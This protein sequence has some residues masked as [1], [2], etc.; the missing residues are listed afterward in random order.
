[1]IAIERALRLVQAGFSIIPIREDKRP[2]MKWKDYQTRKATS[3]ELQELTHRYQPGGFGIVTG[4][5]GL[6]CV[7]VDL[8]NFPTLQE[9][10]TFFKEF[11]EMLHDNIDDFERKFVIYK[12]M[13][14]GYHILYKCLSPSG[15]VALAKRDGKVIVET[16]GEGGFVVAYKNNVTSL[17]YEDI[18]TISDE[19]REILLAVCRDFDTPEALVCEG[20][21][22]MKVTNTASFQ[23]GTTPWDD[24]NARKNVLDVVGDQFRI[25]R[26]L[27]DRILILR[28]GSKAHH[29]G[30]I[31]KESGILQ[32]W[33][34]STAYP[35]KVGHTPFSL[36]TWRYHGGNYSD[37]AKD[38]YKQGFGTRIKREPTPEIAAEEVVNKSSE[39][40]IDVF[41]KVL[42]N[43]LNECNKTL[44]VSI[45]YMGGALLWLSAVTIGNMVKLKVK[46]GWFESANIWLSLVGQAGIGK[47]PSTNV[48]LKPLLKTN[49]FE[50]KNYNKEYRKFLE[51]SKMTKDEKK[52]N[53]EV[54]EPKRNYFIVNDVT[55][56]ALVDLHEDVPTGVGVHK[57]ELAGW[58]KDMN[59]YREGSDKEFWLSCWSGQSVAITRKT[60][61]SNYV[62]SPCIPV[63]GGIQPSIFTSFATEENKDNGFIDRML[64]CY[65]DLVVQRINDNELSQ[66]MLDWYDGYINDFYHSCRRLFLKF[67]GMEEVESTICFFSKEAYKVFKSADAKLT[68]MQNSPK[69]NEYVK[70]M[71]AKQKSYLA[72]FSLL[73]HFLHSHAEGFENNTK[74][75]DEKCVIGAVKLSDYFIEMSK[76][77]KSDSMSSYELRKLIKNMN[78]APAKDK[79]IEIFSKMPDANKKE[80]AELLNITR[81]SI[82]NYLKNEPA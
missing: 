33:T 46:N 2:C 66:E 1:M 5:D 32:L 9:G 11:T 55:V 67:N 13:N 63:I 78:G 31:F 19:D 17:A 54:K 37:A 62:N 82:Y 25:V 10:Q 48:I 6:E 24:F 39:F 12:T 58:F 57:D 41:P 3:E 26:Q 76:K 40:P 4:V 52:N 16:R 80:V 27:S 35:V 23:D 22:K 34:D 42:Q 70:S 15:N 50:Q 61:K 14:S 45:D 30:Y 68:D 64:I 72:R 21:Q 77:I 28:I 38:L 44:N 71:L 43:Y 53:P 56:E 73:L 47:T 60:S 7:D 49:D 36:Y 8:K 65:P 20:V 51:Y 75:I 29:S 59:K 74:V 18:I 81:Q 69:E 79:V